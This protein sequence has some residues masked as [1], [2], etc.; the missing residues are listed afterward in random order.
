[1]ADDPTKDNDEH[2]DEDEF[3]DFGALTNDSGLGGEEEEDAF[4]TGSLPPLSD[5]DSSE[6]GGSDQDSDLPPLDT[7]ED[8]GGEEDEDSFSGLPPIVDIRVDTPAVRPSDLDTPE[9]SRGDKEAGGEP[10]ETPSPAG[11]ETPGGEDLASPEEGGFGFQDFA[12]DSDFSPE[13]PEIGPGPDSDIETPMF[14]SAFGGDSDEFSTGETS[15][16]PTQAMETPMFGSEEG[17]GGGDFGFDQ[18]AFGAPTPDIGGDTGTPVPDFSP[19][20]GAGVPE[21]GGLT[22]AAAGPPPRRG[23]R[24][25]GV[26]IGLLVAIAAFAGGMYV[27]PLMIGTIPALPN[28]FAEDLQNKDTTIQQLQL[29]VAELTKQP[30]GVEISP[31]RV[32]ELQNEVAKAQGEL[33]RVNDQIAQKSEEINTLNN[34]LQLVRADIEDKNNEFVD[35]QEAL[36][37]L[38]NE[39][40]ITRARHEGLLA[41]N[42]RLTQTVGELEVA[43][44]RRQAT[45]DTLLHNVDLLIIQIQGGSPLTPERF[46]YQER[47]ARANALRDKV[48]RAKWVDPQ[49]LDEYT[50]LY[51]QELAIA[52][53]REYFYAR[54]PVSDRLGNTD[55]EWAECLMNGNWSV[56]FRT[57]DGSNVGSYENTAATGPPK[58]EFREDLPGGVRSDIVEAI[59][60][61]RPEDWKDKFKVLREKEAIY[62]NKTAFQKNYS[63]L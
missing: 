50:S 56:Y 45:K 8:E 19:D 2:K 57:L 54:I 21:T 60:A 30:K 28:P 20:T 3:E 5:F 32:E 25:A 27:G 26:I 4:G 35:T 10:A 48:A 43:N 39:T 7:P 44:A 33:N 38:K 24:V 61:A 40:A 18:D 31:Q 37:D 12:A 52:S 47:L 34:Q 29:K 63:S 36:D 53:S 41:E 15:S 14:D 59:Q 6:G 23:S 17:E 46:D 62:D 42:E 9:P 13:T 55:Y 51:L 58:Y 22:P 1:M 11:F 16:A 49:L